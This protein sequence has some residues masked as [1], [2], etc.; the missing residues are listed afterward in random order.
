[1]YSNTWAEHLAHLR[2]YLQLIKASGFTLGLRQCEF[3]KPSITFL[4]HVIGSDKRSIDPSMVYEA[5]AKIKYPE[6][7]KAVRRITGFFS[8]WRE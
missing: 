7:K 5:V 3:D 6:T 8:Y 2:H 4:G 1:V